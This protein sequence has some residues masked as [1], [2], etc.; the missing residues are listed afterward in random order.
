MGGAMLLPDL[1]QSF[2]PNNLNQDTLDTLMRYF[3]GP[4]L[5]VTVV[6]DTLVEGRPDQ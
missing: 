6:A 5:P 3:D 1:A 4:G 2:C